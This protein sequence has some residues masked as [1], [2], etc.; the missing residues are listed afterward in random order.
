M[1]TEKSPAIAV[2]GIVGNHIVRDGRGGRPPDIDSRAPATLTI[3]HGEAVKN[4]SAPFAILKYH[5]RPGLIS[6]NDGG[7]RSVFTS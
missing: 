5:N 7:T 3:C 1:I 2:G 6:V 4:G